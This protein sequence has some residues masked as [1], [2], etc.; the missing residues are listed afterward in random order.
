MNIARYKSDSLKYVIYLRNELLNENRSAAVLKQRSTGNEGVILQFSLSR[1]MN[2]KSNG[3]MMVERCQGELC[4]V[5]TRHNWIE[6]A[7]PNLSA[8]FSIHT[9]FLISVNALWNA[10]YLYIYITVLRKSYF[11]LS[12]FLIILC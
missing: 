6:V 11:A 3:M 1:Q 4:L 5:F 2:L 8:S 7:P 9:D 10:I 12:L